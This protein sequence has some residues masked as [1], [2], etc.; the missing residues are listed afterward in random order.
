MRVLGRGGI[1]PEPR[2]DRRARG[3]LCPGLV[4]DNFPWFT[5]SADCSS[6]HHD[7]GAVQQRPGLGGPDSGVGVCGSFGAR[8][9]TAP[10]PRPTSVLPQGVPAPF[11]PGPA[12][13][14]TAT[15]DGHRLSP[16]TRLDLGSLGRCPPSSLTTPPAWGQRST[17][18]S[19]TLASSSAQRQTKLWSGDGE[20][21]F[22]R[23]GLSAI[24]IPSSFQ[25]R[26]NWP[27]SPS[28]RRWKSPAPSAARA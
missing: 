26:W 13:P 25:G 27:G 3:G 20:R 18:T 8:D 7:R 6:V 24:Q 16:Q 9:P 19:D 4:A 28:P 15:A 12:R 1:A 23:G 10:L 21:R 14:W 17:A 22:K 5:S 11:S 2:R